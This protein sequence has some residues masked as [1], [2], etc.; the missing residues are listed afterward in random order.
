VKAL[1]IIFAGTPEFSVPCL[2]ALAT[3]QHQ[4]QAIYTQPDR[5]A[6][7]GRKLQISAVK[8]QAQ[9]LGLQVLQPQNFKQDLD[10]E[11]L[12]SFAPDI[13][14]VI[15]YGLILPQR[16]LEIPTLGCINVHGSLLPR[17]RGASPIQQ[18]IL[19]GD[20]A[21]GIT[22]MHMD[23]GLDTGNILMQISCSIDKQNS[24]QLYTLLANIAV[25]PLLT[26]LEKITTGQIHAEA[27]N[28][29]YATYAPKINKT[30]AFINWQQ[31]AIEIERKIRAFNPQPIAYTIAKGIS[32]RIY[33]ACVIKNNHNKT[34][35]T[36]LAIDKHGML[37]AANEDAVLIERLQFPGAKSLTVA[38]WLNA[39]N[40]QLTV[41]LVLG[42]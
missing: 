15:A 3:S 40:V 12:K 36:I 17:W 33:Q 13:M 32:I 11:L 25:E 41:D 29:N 23:K 4:L 21:T 24:A 8:Q 26:T 34:P 19:H 27:Q 7:R 38:E 22:I 16:V 5:P 10:I 6:G 37:V 42:L 30:D 20:S 9:I 35:G 2:N 39:A 28:D 18:A 14:I 1:K 31:K